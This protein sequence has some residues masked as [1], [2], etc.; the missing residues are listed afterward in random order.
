MRQLLATESVG[1]N[2]LTKVMGMSHEINGNNCFL[3]A[4]S[5]Q[6]S[7]MAN[8][9]GSD[10]LVLNTNSVQN[11]SQLM[12]GI[13]LNSFNTTFNTLD[14]NNSVI[15][16]TNDLSNETSGQQILLVSSPVEVMTVP[17][18]TLIAKPSLQPSVQMVLQPTNLPLVTSGQQ[19]NVIQVPTNLLLTDNNV[20]VIP[21]DG[22]TLEVPTVDANVSQQTLVDNQMVFESDSQTLVYNGSQQ[23]FSCYNNQ[24]VDHLVVNLNDCIAINTINDK[25]ISQSP[26]G[27]QFFQNNQIIGIIDGNT[28]ET[29][30]DM[31]DDLNT[32]L[33]TAMTSIEPQEAADSNEAKSWLND[34]LIAYRAMAAFKKAMPNDTP[35]PTSGIQMPVQKHHFSE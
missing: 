21:Q 18:Q 12:T 8:C 13:E 1:H 23:L 14:L 32:F 19:L 7:S 20:I 35:S 29:K 5:L 34:S 11:M 27:T 31:N 3:T 15:I 9:G 16:N 22:L 17:Q 26:D 25:V 24:N 10:T 30:V 2:C 4:N 33:A 6:I 28:V